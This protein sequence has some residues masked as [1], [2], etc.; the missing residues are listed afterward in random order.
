MQP[1]NQLAEVS[2]KLKA[3]NWK[4]TDTIEPVN[5]GNDMQNLIGVFNDMAHEI[6][7]REKRMKS[8]I[9]ELELKIDKA[10]EERMVSEITETEFFKQLERKSAELRKKRK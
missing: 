4:E 5:A 1:I 10:K 7:I 8:T 9:R 3:G 6:Q 2:D